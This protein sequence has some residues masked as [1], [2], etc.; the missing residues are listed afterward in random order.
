VTSSPLQKPG[1][2]CNEDATILLAIALWGVSTALIG[3]AADTTRIPSRRRERVR[4]LSTRALQ[5]P[6][7][8]A[9]VAALQVYPPTTPGT[10][11]GPLAVHSNSRNVS[12]P[13]G[14]PNLASNYDM[15]MF[16]CRPTSAR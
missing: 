10:S 3:E 13:S 2:A 12:L 9:V 6:E 15:G 4:R 11:G 7:A 1:L 14:P 16:S 5:H 8:D